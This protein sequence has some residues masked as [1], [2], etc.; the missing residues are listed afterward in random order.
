MQSLHFC[1][2]NVDKSEQKELNLPTSLVPS[3][4]TFE[5]ITKMAAQNERTSATIYQFPVRGRFASPKSFVQQES[6]LPT[7]SFGDAWYHDNAM[8]EEQTAKSRKH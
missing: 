8:K 4:S 6:A 2:A 1:Q 7:V 5:E 3:E